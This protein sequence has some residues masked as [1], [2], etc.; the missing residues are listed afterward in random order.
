MRVLLLACV[1]MGLAVT[2]PATAGADDDLQVVKRA[3]GKKG[4]SEEGQPSSPA[5]PRSREAHWFK[6][7]IVDK[8]TGRQKVSMS[9]P[10]GL[11]EIV[12]DWPLDDCHGWRREHRH[13]HSRDTL[14][15]VLSAL[16]SG[17]DLVQ[18]DDEG[19]SVRVWVE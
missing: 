19:T 17:R 4:G 14:R 16:R 12:G 15:E 2:R 7:R 6:V 3:V 13:D 8:E 5:S 11:V 9:L 18:I 10:L 1:T